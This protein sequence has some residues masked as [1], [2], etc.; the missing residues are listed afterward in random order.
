MA[1]QWTVIAER[2]QWVL[3]RV[4]EGIKFVQP[5]H[6]CFENSQTKHFQ[7]THKHIHKHTLQVHKQHVK[8]SI[9]RVH[10]YTI[11]PSTCI[12]ECSSKLVKLV[13]VSEDNTQ[14][15]STEGILHNWVKRALP[16]AE[17]VA[18]SVIFDYPHSHTKE[19]CTNGQHASSMWMHAWE[20]T[21]SRQLQS[22]H[23]TSFRICAQ[24][25]TC[26][27]IIIAEPITQLTIFTR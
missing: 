24:T 9:I 10:T 4:F 14:S 27:Y 15:A 16:W 1:W 12:V 7:H 17:P 19:T 25:H 18:T 8:K 21:G 6:E 2:T 5:G 20:K 3:P 26:T 11:C 23:T 22:T 13:R